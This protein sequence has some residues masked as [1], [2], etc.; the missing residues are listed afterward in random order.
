MIGAKRNQIKVRNLPTS[1]LA[2]AT[3]LSEIPGIS[4]FSM[5]FY[6]MKKSVRS[7]WDIKVRVNIINDVCE[8]SYVELSI[9]DYALGQPRNGVQ[10][11]TQRKANS[12]YSTA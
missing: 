11:K 12:K 10:Y 9:L 8:S 5:E 3:A 2:I 7:T 4:N 1:K 6:C